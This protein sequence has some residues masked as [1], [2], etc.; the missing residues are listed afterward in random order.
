MRDV[1]YGSEYIKVQLVQHPTGQDFYFTAQRIK[2]EYSGAVKDMNDEE[3]R[4]IVLEKLKSPGGLGNAG[5]HLFFTFVVDGVSR[6]TTHQLVRTRIGASFSQESQRLNDVR[7]APFRMP[8][9]VKRYIEK[10]TKCVDEVLRIYEAIRNSREVYEML[11]DSGEVPYQDARY[12][13]PIGTTTHIYCSYSYTTL[14]NLARRRLCK[15]VQ[16]EINTVLRLMKKAVCDV[17]SFLDSSW[18]VVMETMADAL[19][20]PCKTSGK[21]FSN[22]LIFP[23][24][25]K[26][27]QGDSLF[28]HSLNAN[29]FSQE[30]K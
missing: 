17:S 14:Y 4:K 23:S 9:T 27:E 11:I 5:E 18:S 6:A 28:P 13:L 30:E 16:W 3:A 26:K 21:C 8:E 29:Q 22:E 1:L 19:Q 25:M 24:C 10:N 12:F 20:P 7:E 15:G 2:A